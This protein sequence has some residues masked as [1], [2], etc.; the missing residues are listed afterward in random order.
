LRYVG[1]AA[2]FQNRT[3]QRIALTLCHHSCG[4]EFHEKAQT[5]HDKA[6]SAQSDRDGRDLFWR[7]LHGFEG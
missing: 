2:A 6:H 5:G 3:Q 7:N 1:V 4:L